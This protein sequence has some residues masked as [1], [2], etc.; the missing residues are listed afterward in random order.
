MFTPLYFRRQR[1][2]QRSR[3]D[4]R[5]RTQPVTGLEVD[6]A[7]K[8]VQNVWNVRSVQNVWNVIE[9]ISLVFNSCNS[10]WYS[11]LFRQDTLEAFRTEIMKKSSLNVFDQKRPTVTTSIKKVKGQESFPQ[12]FQKEKITDTRR[13]GLRYKTMPVTSG[14]LMKIP[15]FIM[16]GNNKEINTGTLYATI[17]FNNI[18][19]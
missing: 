4:W 8:Y 13:K 7:N 2:L 19:Y 3:E 11:K 6:E 10:H 1:Y 18:N 9:V 17:V 5:V 14:E 12:P 16:N 15:E